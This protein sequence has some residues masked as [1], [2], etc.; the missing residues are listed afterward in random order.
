MVF[1]KFGH[2][3]VDPDLPLAE[4]EKTIDRNGNLNI[5]WKIYRPGDGSRGHGDRHVVHGHH[6]FEHGSIIVAGRTNLDTFAWYTGRL[7]IGVFDDDV[8]GGPIA[9]LEVRGEGKSKGRA[10]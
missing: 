4:Q 9:L 1:S 6:Q 7:V 5:L 8:P 3:G 2:A 10:A